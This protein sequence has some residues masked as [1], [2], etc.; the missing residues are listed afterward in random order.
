MRKTEQDQDEKTDSQSDKTVDWQTGTIIHS[1]F[2][3]P[4]LQVTLASCD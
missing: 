3:L 2:Y 1:D 4:N